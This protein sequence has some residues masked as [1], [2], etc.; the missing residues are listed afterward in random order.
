MITQRNT[1]PRF[2]ESTI[3]LVSTASVS[4]KS[5]DLWLFKEFFRN[6]FCGLLCNNFFRISRE[7]ATLNR[8]PTGSIAREHHFTSFYRIFLADTPLA[9]TK[10]GEVAGW[11]ARR[12]KTPR[13]LA[14]AVSRA[15]WRWQ[16]KY[17]QPKRAGIAPYFQVIA[18]SMVFFYAINYGKI[19]EFPR[20]SRPQKRQPNHFFRL[21]Q[22]QSTTETTSIT[23]LF[24]IYA[25]RFSYKLLQ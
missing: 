20:L 17:A 4:I 14:G 21:L 7:T 19:S 16:H 15:F 13:A 10:V 6:L 24:T 5:I 18:A 2:M 1:T 9:Q 22:F 12:D 23:N 3:R 25:P 11:L 8:P